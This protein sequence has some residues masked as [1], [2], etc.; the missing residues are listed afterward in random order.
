M[1]VKNWENLI[2]NTPLIKLERIF[3]N[4]KINIYAKLEQFNLGGSI[5]DRPALMMIGQAMHEGKIKQG[6]TVIESSSGNMGI[7]LAYVCLRYGLNF[8]AVVDPRTTKANIGIL[9]AL[10]AKIEMVDWRGETTSS[11]L[12][13]R[14]ERVK[15]LLNEMPGS[16]WPNQHANENNPRAHHRTMEEID[17]ALQGKIDYLFCAASTCGTLRGCFEYIKEKNLNAKIIVVDAEGSIIFG[18]TSGNRLIPGH[19]SAIRPEIYRE[20][21]ADKVI[22][23]NDAECV[24]G[25]RLLLKE[26]AIFAGGSSGAIVSGFA[27]VQTEI[28]ENSNVVMILPD[29]GERYLDTIYNIQ[30]RMDK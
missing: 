22:Y 15:Q 25:C 27:K 17:K 14:F 9:E 4:Q 28:P 24:A 11:Y 30:S 12:E 20:G 8:I 1:K 6:A 21:M 19:G 29:R 10:G 2:G 3:S 16:F 26:E 7:A 23:V 13:A 18:G 5:K